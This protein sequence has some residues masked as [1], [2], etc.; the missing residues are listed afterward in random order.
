MLTL[1]GLTGLLGLILL[2]KPELEPIP[3]EETK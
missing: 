2:P 1:V 3:V